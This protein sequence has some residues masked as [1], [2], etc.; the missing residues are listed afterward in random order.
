VCVVPF[1]ILLHQQHLGVCVNVCC[2]VGSDGTET[3][4]M[5]L[6]LAFGEQ[7]VGKGQV[8]E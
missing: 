8:F 5:L 1:V 7:T 2:K 4:E 6:E 3:L